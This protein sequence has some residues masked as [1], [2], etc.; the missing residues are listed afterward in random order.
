MLSLSG[1]VGESLLN[2]VGLVAF[3]L[4]SMAAQSSQDCA[5]TLRELGLKVGSKEPS[6]SLV[7]LGTASERCEGTVETKTARQHDGPAPHLL[8]LSRGDRK[9]G[10]EKT[11]LVVC[12]EGATVLLEF[13][14]SKGFD[15]RVDTACKGELKWPLTLL[16]A[17]ALKTESMNFLGKEVV[18]PHRYVP[19]LVGSEDAE[20]SIQAKLLFPKPL[21]AF[22]WR[23]GVFREGQGKC[24]STDSWRREGAKRGYD[25]MLLEIETLDLLEET[26]CIDLMVQES[27]EHTPRNFYFRTTGF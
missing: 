18:K 6:Y 21:S 25:V 11:L 27:E 8:S 7:A 4:A 10:N 23:L 1:K 9:A 13:T 14:A 19:L 17:A 3:L 22:A 5:K 15:Y 2:S 20:A 16:K 24:Q 26:D 12:L